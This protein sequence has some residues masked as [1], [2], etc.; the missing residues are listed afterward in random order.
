VT[1]KLEKYETGSIGL[2]GFIRIETGAGFSCASKKAS[3]FKPGKCC[4]DEMK[5]GGNNIDMISHF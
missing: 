3:T 4:M 1:F 2:A 5:S